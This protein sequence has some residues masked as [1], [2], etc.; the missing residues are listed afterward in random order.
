MRALLFVLLTALVFGF[1]VVDNCGYGASKVD[2]YA[3]DVYDAYCNAA[4]KCPALCP[5]FYIE[6]KQLQ[7]VGG[8]S[9]F[10]FSGGAVCVSKIEITCGLSDFS[11][12]HII[13][14]EFGHALQAS[15][16]KYPDKFN[17]WY[18]EAVPEAIASL[19]M[20]NKTGIPWY[21][22]YFPRAYYSEEL[23]KINPFSIQ[24]YSDKLYEYKYSGAVAWLMVRYGIGNVYSQYSLPN[25]TYIQESY[26]KFLLSPWQ[27]PY[28]PEFTSIL[29]VDRQM[30]PFTGIYAY[31]FRDYIREPGAL[32]VVANAPLNGTMSD[33]LYLAFAPLTSGTLSY[34]ITV[35]PC[36][37]ITTVTNTTTVTTTYT[38]TVTNT[39]TTTTTYTT[40]IPVTTTTTV[41]VLTTTT[42]TETKTYTVTETVPV[43][44]TVTVTEPGTTITQTVPVT[45]TYTTT[46]VTT[47]T[48]TVEKTTTTTYVTTITEY[49]TL[50]ETATYTVTHTSTE[51][52]TTTVTVPEFITT[53]DSAIILAIAVILI[54]IA[55]AI[56]SRCKQ[57]S[58]S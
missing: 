58:A 32:I 47:V 55:V 52:Y 2:S 45:T 51:T 46:Y 33:N 5:G 28:K 1:S 9:Y 44:Y 41:T 23:Y 14:H 8:L 27:W 38:T 56:C 7:N 25:I 24:M 22:H 16:L 42:V 10:Q 43:T 29:V 18:V 20:Q 30:V 34:T 26:V 54:L 48:E 12:R 13:A 3:K 15:F 17:G 36:G 4:G 49:R 11:L 19:Y 39:Y 31:E 50:T 37:N 6:T 53:R 35:R 21:Q 57:N 40:T